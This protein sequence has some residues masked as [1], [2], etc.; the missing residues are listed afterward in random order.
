[1]QRI[2]FLLGLSLLAQSAL[3]FQFADGTS[4]VATA[5]SK[6]IFYWG[7]HQCDLTDAN[8]YK[9]NLS[10]SR[11]AFRQLLLHP[12]SIWD[13]TNLQ[14]NF[15]FS[16]EN[17]KVNTENY[18]AQV[19]DLDAALSPKAEPGKVL[20]L[21][22]LPLDGSRTG[23]ID[24]R[25]IDPE[26]KGKTTPA[27]GF[28]ASNQPYIHENYL[29]QV[30]WGRE[31][32]LRNSD[33][34]F[35]TEAEF[36]QTIRQQPYAEWKFGVEPQAL[37]AGVQLQGP[38]QGTI[39][40]NTNLDN[41]DE[42][43]QMLDVLSNYK[44]LAHAGSSVTLTLQTAE[45][46][47]DLYR[48]RMVLVPDNDPRLRLRRSRDMHT[49]TIQWGG[50]INKMEGLYLGAYTNAEGISVPIDEPVSR[51][52]GVTQ[53][54][55][56]MIDLFAAR[57]V[58]LIDGMEVPGLTFN[59]HI[60]DSIHLRTDANGIPV[61]SPGASPQAGKHI[62]RWTDEGS[63]TP[64][65]PPLLS[66]NDK[67][68]LELDSFSLEGYTLPPMFFTVH[69][70]ALTNELLVR[71]DFETLLKA[72]SEP[73]RAMMAQTVITP[74]SIEIAFKLPKEAFVKISLF[75]DNGRLT[76]IRMSRFGKGANKM[77]LPRDKSDSRGKH[78][79][80]LNTP[81]GV[82]KQEIELE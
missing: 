18:A 19:G 75:E 31:D 24:I 8:A 37:R 42:Y 55:S 48:K 78:Y 57:L 45:R 1:M 2:F 12:P 62:Y 56:A 13:G 70:I 32:I 81:F 10:V 49:L 17:K 21:T 43:R 44:H 68:E 53:T 29:E 27:R 5:S 73:A 58:C 20:H 38:E 15:A 35:F 82:L 3:A 59:L 9:G 22:G 33:R 14:R 63:M 6:Y 54:D 71:N 47:E 25:I 60:S 7:Q 46:Y 40:L 50:F 51:I 69:F 41:G 52:V 28:W 39:S 76:R 64:P 61:T 4:T 80:F 26:E 66:P 34:D 65:I 23:S 36:W 16:L 74:D 67:V 72:A 79:L 30:V 77:T 11:G